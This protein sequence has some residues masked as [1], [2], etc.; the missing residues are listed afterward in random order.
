M[1]LLDDN[2][3]NQI[4]NQ[5]DNIINISDISWNAFDLKMKLK[6]IHHLCGCFINTE[7]QN[8]VLTIPLKSI[9]PKKLI[10]FCNFTK[11]NNADLFKEYNLKA[12][13]YTFDF[14]TK[15]VKLTKRTYYNYKNLPQIEYTSILNQYNL[16]V[17]LFLRENFNK[18]NITN[19]FNYLTDTNS[20]KLFLHNNIKNINLNIEYENNI[21]ILTFSNSIIINL[22]LVYSGD[23]ISNNIP[24]IYQI[25]LT[26]Y[27]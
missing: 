26:N 21:L 6:Y 9:K 11:S 24:V 1:V 12:L 10:N 27:I 18:I 15:Y 22:K 5:I 25:I 4:I 17:Y 14:R 8:D 7:K 19:L 2:V 20:D 16:L 23:L 3:K 13:E